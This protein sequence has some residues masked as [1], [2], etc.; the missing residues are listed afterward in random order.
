MNKYVVIVCGGRRYDDAARVYQVLDEIVTRPLI[1][2]QGDAV[3][4]DYLAK[5]WAGSRGIHC[6]TVP[7]LWEV[8]GKSAGPI[9]NEAMLMLN[10]D[11]VIAFPGGRGT[12]DMVAR[13]NAMGVPVQVVDRG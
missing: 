1:I 3:G 4:A 11:L 5:M 8:N 7:A 9:R 12:A 10:P 6:A 13:A 2:V